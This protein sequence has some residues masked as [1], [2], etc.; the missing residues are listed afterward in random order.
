MKIGI[1]GNTNLTYKVIDFLIKEKDDIRYVFG[2]P[3]EKLKIKV[4]SYDLS[5]ICQKEKIKFIDSNDWSDIM[6]EKVD[7]VYEMGDSRIVPLDFLKKNQVIGN[8]G[9]ILPNVQ[10]AASLVWGRLLNSGTWGVSLMDLNERVDSGD[11]LMTKSIF[12]DKDSTSMQEFVEKCDNATID[13][14]KSYHHNDFV[15][16]ENELWSVKV[17]PF[18]DT[19]TIVDILRFCIQKNINIYLPPRKP[20][21]SQICLK[22]EQNFINIFKKANNCPYPKYFI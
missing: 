16:K 6:N 20:S 19:S 11:I 3:E 15:R 17:S 5:S 12:Y 1:I 10:G 14:V 22:W 21:D 18:Q 9:A 4:N 13:C 8:H 2:L 7:I